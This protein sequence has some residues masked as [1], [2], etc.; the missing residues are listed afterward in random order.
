MHVKFHEDITIYRGNIV[1]CQ[2]FLPPFRPQPFHEA[3]TSKITENNSIVIEV[4]S[5]DDAAENSLMYK[6]QFFITMR[7]IQAP[8]LKRLIS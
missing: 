7:T 8:V 6:I 1:L 2:N 3:Y 4:H 5:T